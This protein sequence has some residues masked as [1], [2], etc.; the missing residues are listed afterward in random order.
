LRTKSGSWVVVSG[1]S[2]HRSQLPT[3]ETSYTLPIR[4]TPETSSWEGVV[5]GRYG[6]GGDPEVD[7][8][9][10]AAK[11]TDASYSFF[12]PLPSPTPN[13]TCYRGLFLGAE[14]IWAGEPVRLKMPGDDPVVLIISRIKETRSADRNESV[15]TIAGDVYKFT[16]MS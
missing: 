2:E 15:V 12:S 10:L 13:E 5:S 16:G 9:I 1:L 4:L 14:K 7:G 8:S 11:S 6:Q 3:S